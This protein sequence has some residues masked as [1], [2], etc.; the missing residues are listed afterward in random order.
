MQH[1]TEDIS[2]F[3]GKIWDLLPGEIKIVFASPFSKFKLE[4]G[5]LINVYANFAKNILK[6]SGIFDF[7]RTFAKLAVVF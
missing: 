1:G 4:N 7:S 6:I 5:P 2:N 3:G